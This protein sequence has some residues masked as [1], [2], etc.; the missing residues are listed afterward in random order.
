[1]RTELSSAEYLSTESE[2]LLMHR[3]RSGWL[4]EANADLEAIQSQKAVTSTNIAATMN[5]IAKTKLLLDGLQQRLSNLETEHRILQSLPAPI[6]RLPADLLEEIFLH[7]IP[8]WCE[9]YALDED[10]TL[11]LSP[12]IIASVC[13][14]WRDVALS[15][16]PLWATIKL[17]M[18]RHRKN[19]STCTSSI[20]CISLHIQRA[21]K[22]PLSVIL[23][24]WPT[25]PMDRARLDALTITSPT[26]YNLLVSNDMDAIP[27]GLDGV[28]IR[29]LILP[30]S[31][32][33]SPGR[34][35]GEWLAFHPHLN[36]LQA[37]FVP[38]P[39][40]IEHSDLVIFQSI[41]SLQRVEFTQSAITR[42]RPFLIGSSS[43][44]ALVE[45]LPP[46]V[47][48][49]SF[50]DCSLSSFEASAPLPQNIRT[51][52]LSFTPTSSIFNLLFAFDLSTIISLSISFPYY[53][54]LPAE[55]AGK[56]ARYSWKG[57]CVV[58]MCT[59]TTNLRH[60]SLTG[61][62]FFAHD[63][64]INDSLQIPRTVLQA[65]SLLESLELDNTGSMSSSDV[66]SIAELL[67]PAVQESERL[68]PKLRKLRIGPICGAVET[69]AWLSFLDMVEERFK[70]G[71]LK[72]VALISPSECEN[73]ETAMHET[74]TETGKLEGWPW[75]LGNVWV[76]IRTLKLSGLVLSF[77]PI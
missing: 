42:N 17:D 59:T 3:I 51:L 41:P 69:D 39:T 75:D 18:R 52:S 77:P 6:R 45:A 11:Y 31:D 30:V 10:Y 58:F 24:G 7:S 38:L 74:A 36:A 12:F 67:T 23:R 65:T 2:D 40:A 26:W 27:P 72:E 62:P 53:R 57:L 71:H 49:A 61:F 19:A 33:A 47:D 48:T 20:E 44:R 15:C 14:R 54:R 66:L 8:V 43:L 4:P 60:L 21:S 68:F 13:V 29:T 70:L 37:L 22:Y 73:R 34:L 46:S 1:M 56:T 76:R 32:S 55:A 9:E 35:L 5:E 64:V 16:P 25:T 50:I 63:P 28:N